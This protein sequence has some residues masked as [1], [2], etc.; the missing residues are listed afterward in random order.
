MSLFGKL[1]GRK[2]QQPADAFDAPIA[3]DQPFFVIGDIHGALDPFRGL[4]HVIEQVEERPTVVCVGDYIDRGDQSNAILGLL[5]R[6][7][8]EFPDL[9]FCLKGN[10]E[11]MCMQF[12][13]DPEQ[14]GARWMR[15][16]GLQTL[17][18]FGIGRGADQPLTDVRDK[19]AEAMGGD[20]IDWMYGLPTRW[21][22]GNVA[23]VHAGADPTVPI[24]KQSDRTLMW[25]H[26]DFMSTP[27]QDGIWVAHGHTIVKRPHCESGR[28]AVDTG[29]YATG[30]L[31]G[32]YITT[33][34]VVF[35]DQNLQLD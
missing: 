32:A 13:E 28:I 35:I 12:L 33:D 5:F 10:H 14:H 30:I 27:R 6:L 4:L 18:S 8:Q 23:V 15:H 29:A 17:A 3:P 11:H 19:L 2:A 31:S 22:S 24:D 21:Q 26:S 25:G 9:F 20:L 7:T 1:L 16:G 34:E